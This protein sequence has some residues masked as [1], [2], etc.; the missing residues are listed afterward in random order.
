MIRSVLFSLGLSTLLA[1][2]GHAQQGTLEYLYRYNCQSGEPD[3]LMNSAVISGDRALIC[4]NRGI[5][6]VDLGS[7]PAGGSNSYLYRLLGINCRD[8]Y[9]S[10]DEE[11]VFVNTHRASGGDSFGFD[12]VRITGNTLSKV[13]AVAESEVLYEKMC[14]VGDLLYVAAHSHGLRV[15]DVSDPAAPTLHGSLEDGFVDAFDVEVS[16]ST[17]YVADGAGGLKVVDVSDPTAPVIVD[18]EDLGSALGTYEELTV[19]DGRL[20]VAVGAVGLA[21]YELPSLASRTVY[22]LAGAAESLCWVGDALA[23]GTFSAT[24]LFEVGAGTQV[25]LLAREQAHRRGTNA[26]L[27]LAEGVAPAPGNRVLV[28]G[29]NYLDVYELKDAGAGTQPDIDCDRQRLRFAPTGGVQSVTVSNDGAGAL[30]VSSVGSTSSAF[31]AS[32]SGGT[33]QPGESVTFDITYAGS[34]TSVG[35]GRILLQSND[36]DENPLPIQV[37]GNTTYL[38][39]GEPATDFTLTTL[40]R[41]SQTGEIVNGPPITLSQQTG[42][43]VWFAVF[44]TW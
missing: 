15:Y 43:V 12:V 21:V 23:V 22:D 35:S 41:D 27:R 39:P 26:R 4:G 34:G 25:T 8:L 42:K 2:A 3:H 31:S 18:G 7:L 11:Y 24:E 10:A 20:Y 16:G 19:R 30:N 14:L 6:L 44:A 28:A 37:F 29:W 40:E 13:T 36:P 33:L 5:A 17:A 1:A 32:W 38:D 9:V